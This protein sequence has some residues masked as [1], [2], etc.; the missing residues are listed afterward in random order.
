[1]AHTL[2]IK[3]R[4]ARMSD[5]DDFHELF[6]NEHTA[7]YLR[8]MVNCKHNGKCDFVIEHTPPSAATKVIGEIGL[9]DGHEIGFMLNPAF[10]AKGIMKEAMHRF[11]LEIWRNEDMHALQDIIADV[12]PRNSACI[13]LL[14]RFGFKETGYRE[15]T[16]KT[17][18]GWCDSLDFELKRPTYSEK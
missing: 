7:E 15:K 13:G 6:S 17:H 8:G 14:Q 3:L 16:L 1:M 12:D 10:W 18:L 5:L 11:L 9:W 2:E 4:A